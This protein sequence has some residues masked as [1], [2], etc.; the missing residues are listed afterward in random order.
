VSLPSQ[1]SKGFRFGPFEVDLEAHELRKNGRQV[2]LQEKPFQVL[3]ALLEEE[4]KLVTREALRQR[5]WPTDIFVD[6]DNGLN[7]AVS[8]LRQALGDSVKKHRYFE[9]L[10]RRGYRFV[11]SIEK[12]GMRAVAHARELEIET[13]RIEPDTVVV[14][15][16]GRI[17]LGPECQQI[18]WLIANLLLENERNIILDISGVTYIDSTGVGIV[19]MCFGKVRKAGGELRVAGAK[20]IVEDL[21][22]MV[23]LDRIMPFYPKAAAAIEG[24]TVTAGRRRG[25]E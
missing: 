10:A 25:C 1:F 15:I 7:T 5:L 3:V 11:I 17:V 21:L 19:A 16:T 13:K 2:R 20:G 6:F 4:G 23:K 18:E 24:F 14:E 9:T 22:R 12:L 8:K